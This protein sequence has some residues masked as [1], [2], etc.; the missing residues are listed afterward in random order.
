MSSLSL[1]LP[2]TTFSEKMSA[3]K[4]KEIDEDESVGFIFPVL[5]ISGKTM[6]KLAEASEVFSTQFE[7]IR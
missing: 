3:D 2:S 6:K 7:W 1:Y 4:K 5:Q